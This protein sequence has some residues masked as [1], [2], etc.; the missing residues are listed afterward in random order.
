MTLKEQIQTDRSVFFSTDEFADA[1]T[2]VPL[3]GENISC[4]VVVDSEDRFLVDGFEGQAADI[5]D[6]IVYSLSDIG[7]DVK[8]GERFILTDTGEMYV[9]DGIESRDDISVRA[10]VKK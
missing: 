1:A 9:V 8:R 5:R 3:N 6:I 10:F 2:F 7:R 4:S